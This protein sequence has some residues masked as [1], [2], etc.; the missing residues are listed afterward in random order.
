[1]Q[2]YVSFFKLL[3]SHNDISLLLVLHKA[4]TLLLV[5]KQVQV[6]AALV[7][8]VLRQPHQ[9]DFLEILAQQAQP[10]VVEVYLV[11]IPAQQVLEVQT[12]IPQASVSI[13][14]GLLIPD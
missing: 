1:M 12:K 4:V 9:E 2:N 8:L 10:V 13:E 11:Q 7:A 5:Q 6:V 14:I 3:I